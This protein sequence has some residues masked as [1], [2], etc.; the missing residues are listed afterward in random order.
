[1]VPYFP[2]FFIC[3]GPNTNTG[4]VSI[5]YMIESQILFIMKC[6]NYMKKNNLEYIDIKD[7]AMKAYNEKIQNKLSETVWAASCGSWYKTEEGKI[8]NNY[9]GYGM[10]ITG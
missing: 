2:N 6:L 3:Y 1:M 4:H 9:P 10:S 8:V 7:N 5:I